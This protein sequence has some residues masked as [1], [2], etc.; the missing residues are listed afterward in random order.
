MSSAKRQE[1]YRYSA[2]KRAIVASRAPSCEACGLTLASKGE[3]RRHLVVHHIRPRSASGDDD[4]A[5]LILLC[6]RC[7][8]AVHDFSLSGRAAPQL[9]AG[10]VPPSPLSRSGSVRE[11]VIRAIDRRAT[12]GEVS[13]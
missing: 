6:G 4:A 9:P 1:L 2:I 11:L 12:A 8:G 10:V 7:H 13:S 3:A 5:N